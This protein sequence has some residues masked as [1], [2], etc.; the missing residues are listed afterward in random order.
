MKL[1][2]NWK[3]MKGDNLDYAK[4]DFDDSDW[5][6]IR[7][8]KTWEA[9][10]YKNHF[11]FIWY[12][13]HIEIPSE[14]K[15]NADSERDIIFN[16][17]KVDDFDQ[18]YL[19]GELIGA[20]TQS[21]VEGSEVKDSFTEAENFFHYK[22]RRY[23][24]PINSSLIKWDDENII[25]VRVFDWTGDNRLLAGDLSVDLSE[26]YDYLKLEM[27]RG[28]FEKTGKDLLKNIR[29][30]NNS[31][32]YFI[33]GELEIKGINNISEEKF[34]EKKI[35]IKLKP[36]ENFDLKI[37]FSSPEDSS[38]LVFAFFYK[39]K[40]MLSFE[41][42][43][44]Y[45][46]TPESKKKPQIN[47]AEI[48][49]QRPDK[50]FLFKIPTTGKRPI[51]FKVKNL[52]EGLILDSRNGIISGKVTSKGNYKIEI[53][54]TNDFGSDKKFLKIVIGENLALTPPMG[55]NS[56]NCWGLEVN[57]EKIFASAKAFIETGLADHG[58]SFI[59]IDDGWEIF[60]KSKSQKRKENGE[61]I[62]NEKFPN[63]KKL[64]DDIHKLGLKI[65]IYSSPGE[66]TCG[67]YTGS[68]GYELKDAETFAKW[69]ID[70]LK[71]DLCGFRKIMKNTNDP[72]ELIPPYKLMGECLA[73]VNRDIIYSICEYGNGKVWEWG[74]KVGGQLWRTTGDIWDNWNRVRQIGFGKIEAAKY[75]KPGHWNDP[76]MLVVGKIGWGPKLHQTQLTPDEQ[77][78]HVSL[79]AL[80]SAPLLLGNDL[81]ALDEFTKNLIT[82]DEVIAIDQDV[83]GKQAVPII[84]ENGIEVW[85]KILDGDKIAIGIFNLNDENVSYALNLNEINFEKSVLIRDVWKQ[86]DIG[87]FQNKFD[88]V[89]PSHGVKLL[90]IREKRT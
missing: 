57:E 44:P 62:T 82:N 76:D 68:L 8:D 64:A 81:S 4:A 74:E 66:L 3:F 59:N 11:G 70:Y 10:N 54:A 39:E 6:E 27:Q 19:N 30:S 61:I 33:G 43:I 22:K 90:V 32:T 41:E 23:L 52:P 5:K 89:I 88:A 36:Q 1:D 49:G 45:I 13:L 17:G 72:Q 28:I 31:E 51:N 42:G 84:K 65:G 60:G 78:T 77:Y 9:Q 85:Q 80:L 35:P 56:W 75:A 24:V 67:G 53:T 26:N 73:K 18:V 71:Y 38:K 12:R 14:I 69:G 46:L 7:V 58:W 50:P 40:K 63:I 34:Y 29:I 15:K 47:G 21:A 83:T 16:L 25:A 55:W 87:V 2:N 79:W 20:N 48:Y 37:Q 86:K